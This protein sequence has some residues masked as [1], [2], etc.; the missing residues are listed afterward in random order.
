MQE[1]LRSFGRPAVC[2]T[3][4]RDEVFRLCSRVCCLEQ[5]R[6]GEAVTVRE[7]FRNPRSRAGALLSGCKNV[8]PCRAADA[9]TVTVPDWGVTLRVPGTVPPGVRYAGIRAHSFHAEN[10]LERSGCVNCLQ[11]REAAVTEDLFEW[12][13]SFRCAPGGGALIWKVSK[14]VMPDIRIPR[15]LLLDGEEIMLLT[16]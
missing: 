5:G 6:S 9:H 13:V 2:V 8:A 7:F 3:H 16:S 14:E 11:V 15:E 12:T 4:D 1:K 10:G